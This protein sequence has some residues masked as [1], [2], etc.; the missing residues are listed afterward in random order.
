MTTAR[1]ESKELE[2][3][4]PLLSRLEH[5]LDIA[6]LDESKAN[7]AHREDYI[8]ILKQKRKDLLIAIALLKKGIR[9]RHLPIQAAMGLIMLGAGA[10]LISNFIEYSEYKDHTVPKLQLELS[11]EMSLLENS[12]QRLMGYLNFWKN[13]L[14]NTSFSLPCHT[15]PLSG[16]CDELLCPDD[17]MNCSLFTDFIN[18]V[19]PNQCGFI[20]I[21]RFNGCPQKNPSV[22]QCFDSVTNY[23]GYQYDIT[24]INATINYKTFMM[25]ALK[26]P[27]A[28]FYS[29]IGM[30]LF[31]LFYLSFGEIGPSLVLML[32]LHTTHIM[33]DFLS[34]RRLCF[35]LS[36]EDSNKLAE[37][38]ENN[39]IQGNL[40][41][42]SKMLK[43]FQNKLSTA[44]KE[45]EDYESRLAVYMASEED[46]TTTPISL[47][48]NHP[49]AEPK[50]L[51]IILD[52]AGKT[53]YMRVFEASAPVRLSF[54]KGGHIKNAT[55]A[56]NG[57]LNLLY[58]FFNRLTHEESEE[59]DQQGAYSANQVVRNIY[60]FAGFLK[61]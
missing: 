10:Y 22:D 19:L 21:Y 44:D 24:N 20:D 33:S 60:Q 42:Y 11:R 56:R 27:A 16:S 17:S 48:F 61:P 41:S 46:P 50:L 57:R 1:T 52:M 39:E 45:L 18:W 32:T 2:L 25:E 49:M 36:E 4:Q 38:A 26:H 51:N 9:K 12:R 53:D 37:I 8:A 23:C 14:Q 43:Q 5:I 34:S 54:E 59:Y 15:Q 58:S 13:D 31:Y 55:L 6:P 3:S 47:L 29:P 40:T 7:A 28:L 35:N 30:F